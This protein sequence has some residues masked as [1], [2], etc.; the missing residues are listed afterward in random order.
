MSD[1]N[2]TAEQ[3][4]ARTFEERVFAR[5]DALD[6]RLTSLEEGAERKAV[7]TKPI[8]E[9]ALAEIIAARKDIEKMDVR[10]DRIESEVKNTHS[11]FYELR[12]AFKEFRAE[13]REHFPAL[14]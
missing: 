6:A 7:E 12:A 4:D 11:E 9:R 14:K 5:F 10:L 8:W 3:H 1:E 13:V 2:T